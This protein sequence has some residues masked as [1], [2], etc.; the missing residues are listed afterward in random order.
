[1]SIQK[2]SESFLD[3]SWTTP[4]AEGSNLAA[5]FV[6]VCKACPECEIPTVINNYRLEITPGS[7]G[8][9]ETA[10]IVGLEPGSPYRI[11]VRYADGNNIMSRNSNITYTQTLARFVDDDL[12]PSDPFIRRDSD[13]LFVADNDDTLSFT[14]SSWSQLGVEEYLISVRNDETDQ[15][16]GTECVNTNTFE[17]QGEGGSAYSVIITPIKQ[18]GTPIGTITSRSI[19]CPEAIIALRE[20]RN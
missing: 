1:M 12:D 9:T 7:P 3:I 11:T 15:V 13:D 8:S 16:I 10:R 2:I 17:F 14:W 20:D 18:D 6:E 19:L 4:E 5:Y